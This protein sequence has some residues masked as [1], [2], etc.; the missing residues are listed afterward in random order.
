MMFTTFSWGFWHIQRASVEVG[1]QPAPQAI[2][3]VP[4]RDVKGTNL[5]VSVRISLDLA[6][7]SFKMAENGNICHKIS[8]TRIISQYIPLSDIQCEKKQ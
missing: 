1:P 4:F 6:N 2:I 3:F 5:S 8:N 7:S